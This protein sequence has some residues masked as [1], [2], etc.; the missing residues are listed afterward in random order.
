MLVKLFPQ[1]N[2]REAVI[3]PCIC[4]IARPPPRTFAIFPLP[5]PDIQ[6]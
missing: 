3:L 5:L 1:I 6:V 4:I 2:A